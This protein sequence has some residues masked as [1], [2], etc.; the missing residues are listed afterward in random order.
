[1]VV[2]AQSVPQS[3]LT[4]PDALRGSAVPRGADYLGGEACVTIK[5]ILARSAVSVGW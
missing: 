4:P 2:S 1:M 3:I 5:L